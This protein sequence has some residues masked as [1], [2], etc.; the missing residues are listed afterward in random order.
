[1][2]T[3]LEFPELLP[4]P[5]PDLRTW[6]IACRDGRAPRRPGRRWFHRWRF[7]DGRRW[8]AFARDPGGYILRFE[9]ADF[10]V[11]P[12]DQHIDCY[13]AADVPHN[14][15]RHLV[16]DQVLP[17]IVGTTDSLALHGSV[18]GTEAGALAFLGES[19]LGKSTL[20]AKLG[21]RGCTVLSDDC[22]LLRRGTDHF[23]AVPSYPGVRLNPDSLRGVGLGGELVSH[24]SDKR[25]IASAEVAPFAGDPVP[26]ARLYE[27]APRDVLTQARE[28]S[29][30][31]ASPRDAMYALIDYTFHLDIGHAPRLRE[32]FE[33]AGEI[34]ERHGV[35][36]LSFPWNLGASDAVVE[37][38]LRDAGA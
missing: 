13:P 17:L 28:I 7:P 31:P 15:L 33:L 27:V 25:R 14:T 4:N 11:R 10:D 9:V 23:M 35:R 38:V 12:G 26:L 1:M 19:G 5:D 21:Q 16:L 3:D 30:T 29:I 34:V 24:Y 36:R 20:A 37:A 2:I 22:C 18:V 6:R 8:V 32:T